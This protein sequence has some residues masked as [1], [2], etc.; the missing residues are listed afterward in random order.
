VQQA[1]V[2]R[3]QAHR[4]ERAQRRH[5]RE[6]RQPPYAPPVP[7]LVQDGLEVLGEGAEPA[8]A[9][10]ERIV[11]EIL[12]PRQAA[13]DDVAEVVDVEHLDALG[14]RTEQREITTVLRPVE[15]HREDAQTPRSQKRLWAQDRY[16]L[17][18]LASSLAGELGLD[19]RLAVRVHAHPWV[20]LAR[21]HDPGQTVHCGRRDVHKLL[22]AGGAARR[23]YGGRAVHVDGADF[24]RPFAGQRGSC[25]DH[26]VASGEC[27]AQ[28]ALVAYVPK[29]QIVVTRRRGAAV[30]S[31]N[32]DVGNAA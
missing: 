31:N 22:D 30:D 6:D 19:L 8:R 26:G 1:P 29:H 11:S 32:R 21:R 24:A 23:K 3:R 2:H 18:T 13:H 17:T 27:E 14:A 9:D 15:E 28:Q 25:V 10:I 20:L 5:A 7:R 16:V 12:W 4:G